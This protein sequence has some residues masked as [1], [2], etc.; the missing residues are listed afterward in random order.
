MKGIRVCSKEGHHL[1]PRGDN[2][3]VAKKND[4]IKKSSYPEPPKLGTKHA[5]VK[6]IQV[7]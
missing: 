7:C 2:Y 1:F 6:G 4:E 3:E 5:G